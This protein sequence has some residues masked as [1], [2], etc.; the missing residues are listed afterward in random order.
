MDNGRRRVGFIALA[1]IMMLLLLSISYEAYQ[2]IFFYLVIAYFI[3]FSL[4]LKPPSRVPQKSSDKTSWSAFDRKENVSQ[5]ESENEEEYDFFDED[6]S[7]SIESNLQSMFK[8]LNLYEDLSKREAPLT[9]E[10]SE[11]YDKEWASELR[12][13][14]LENAP[15]AGPK[16]K[17]WGT[18]LYE[19]INSNAKKG[20]QAPS[21]APLE[22]DEFRYASDY[23]K[24]EEKVDIDPWKALRSSIKINRKDIE[25]T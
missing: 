4:F 25:E 1:F 14:A 13:G 12:E 16:R 9:K 6:R 19:R 7:A 20:S 22:E 15:S 2:N 3:I 21:K 11:T 5:A 24:K 17:D 18:I 8:E 10:K 23:L